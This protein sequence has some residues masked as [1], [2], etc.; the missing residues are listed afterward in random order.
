MFVLETSSTPVFVIFVISC[1]FEN[2]LC[3]F[4]SSP[5]SLWIRELIGSLS[6]YTLGLLSTIISESI[7]GVETL[8][9]RDTLIFL[10]SF[11]VLPHQ[12]SSYQYHI[13][14][15]YYHTLQLQSMLLFI[16]LRFFLMVQDAVQVPV[17]H[18]LCSAYTK[19]YPKIVFKG[20]AR[21][22]TVYLQLSLNVQKDLRFEVH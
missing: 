16:R 17:S 3:D 21:S 19:S 6:R 1:T 7:C 4:C 20:C 2:L 18:H 13:Y 22:Y 11:L 9:P 15:I 12:T 10:L 8:S 14:T 5:V